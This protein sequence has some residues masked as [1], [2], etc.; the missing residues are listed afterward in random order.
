MVN[1]SYISYKHAVVTGW[2]WSELSFASSTEEWLVLIENLCRAFWVCLTSS[3]SVL[4]SFWLGTSLQVTLLL[5]GTFPLGSWDE[6]SMCTFF[7][8]CCFIVENPICSTFISLHHNLN[9][10]AQSSFC[11]CQIFTQ[12][13]F[14]PILFNQSLLN[15]HF[16]MTTCIYVHCHIFIPKYWGYLEFTERTYIMRLNF[17]LSMNV[18]G[19]SLVFHRKDHL[20]ALKSDGPL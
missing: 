9:E 5:V 4:L 7:S 17:K 16:P 10:A 14:K 6:N 15:F 3:L 20:F 18:T 2:L 19:Y 13:P 11:I 1:S 8:L 12:L